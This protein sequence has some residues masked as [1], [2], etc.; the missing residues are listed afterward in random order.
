MYDLIPAGATLLSADFLLDLSLS[1]FNDITASNIYDKQDNFDFDIE[2][3]LFL[4]GK[5][6]TA[7]SFGVYTPQPLYSTIIGV[8]I[9]NGVS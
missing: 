5:V 3:F 7:T 4:D 9:I 2:N 1:I 6:P 8:H